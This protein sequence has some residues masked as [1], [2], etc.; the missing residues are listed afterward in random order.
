M[1]RRRV[2][3]TSR[4]FS[5]T[6]CPPA[7]LASRA[8]CATRC[9]RAGRGGCAA[10][11][12]PGGLFHHPVAIPD[13]RRLPVA[14][15]CSPVSRRV[16]TEMPAAPPTGGPNGATVTNLRRALREA[17]SQLYE[18]QRSADAQVAKR[19]R[20]YKAMA[21]AASIAGA[22]LLF[23]AGA[24]TRDRMQRRRRPNRRPRAWFLLRATSNLKPPRESC[25]SRPGCGHRSRRQGRE[26]R[27]GAATRRRTADSS[28][29]SPAVAEEGLF[30]ARPA[31]TH[32]CYIV[33]A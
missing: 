31:G 29:A 2:S 16:R 7:A 4:C 15:G 32:L 27:A 25:R 21:I 28:T 19:P 33:G 14:R 11:R 6:C 23:V 10:V 24:V 5:A 26:Q 8:A 22:V 30:I 3:P 9:P 13:G 1:R 12:L 17:D 20:A 18:R